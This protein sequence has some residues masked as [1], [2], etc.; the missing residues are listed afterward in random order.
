MKV[1]LRARLFVAGGPGGNGRVVD[2]ITGEILASYTFATGADVRQRRRAVTPDAAWFTD[3][4]NRC[5]TRCRS[6]R[7]GAARSDRVRRTALRRLRPPA[8]LQRQRHRPYAG[9][10]RRCSS[11]SRTPA[12]CS[13]ST[14]DRRNDHGGPRRSA[15][16]NGDGLWWSG[17]RCTPCRTSQ[18]RRRRRPQRGRNGGNAREDLPIPGSTSRR[19]S[20]PSGPGSTSRTPASPRRRHPP[21]RTARWGSEKAGRTRLGSAPRRAEPNVARAPGSAQVWKS[22]SGFEPGRRLDSAGAPS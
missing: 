7:T 1:D 8:R 10:R 20:R 6:A 11:C 3:S 9:R 21:R 15:L 14:R 17:G 5:S 19:P 2:A 18:P 22:V 12:W 4:I 16:S 13:G